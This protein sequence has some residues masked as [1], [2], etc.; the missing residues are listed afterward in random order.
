[1][2]WNQS[3]IYLA[4]GLLGT[5]NSVFWTS[6]FFPQLVP[7]LTFTLISFKKFLRHSSK[8]LAWSNVAPVEYVA[9][10]V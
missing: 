5:V 8:L 3:L 10:K 4:A 6:L 9:L 7:N 1:M 2:N